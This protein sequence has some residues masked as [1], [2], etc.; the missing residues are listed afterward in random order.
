[1][2]I[3]CGSRVAVMYNM[4]HYWNKYIID[5]LVVLFWFVGVMSFY[6]RTSLIMQPESFVICAIWRSA[7]CCLG[8]SV[9][10]ASVHSRLAC[11]R[12]VPVALTM[13]FRRV[14]NAPSREAHS[15][16]CGLHL[17][18]RANTTQLASAHF[19]FYSPDMH[20]THEHLPKLLHTRY[21]S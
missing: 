16:W 5:S 10:W 6:A 14:A 8:L 1:M 21:T 11:R 7:G 17:P 9:G 4:G 18:T 3:V 15:C 12:G 2:Y 13:S 20:Q 19:C